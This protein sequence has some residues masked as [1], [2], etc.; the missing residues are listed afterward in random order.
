MIQSNDCDDPIAQCLNAMHK[1]P[2][3]K[4]PNCWV[5]LVHAS[6][7][8]AL[9]A[10]S[11]R[12]WPD[13]LIDFG[14][15]L[16][17]AWQISEGRVLYRDIASLF[18]PLSP[19]VNALWFTLFGVS[20][21]T[22]VICNLAI[23][24]AMVAGIHRFVRIATD[25][26][27]ATAASLTVL[28]LFGFCQ[29]LPIGNYNF[30][31]PYSHEAT[32]GIALTIAAL[33]ALQQGLIVRK[34]RFFALAGV[35][36]GLAMLTK[37]EIALAA[38][39]ATCV[40]MAGG[41]FIAPHDGRHRAWSLASFLAA[42]IVP[43]ALFFSYFTAF[44]SASEALRGIG[45]A[46]TSA[47]NASILTNNFYLRGMGLESPAANGV[48]MLLTF[49][50]VMLFLGAAVVVSRLKRGGRAARLALLA[51]A[52][53][54]VQSRTWPAALPALTLT[55]LV[56]ALID[57]WHLGDDRT[58][59]IRLWSL[60]IWAAFALVLLAKIGLNARIVHYGFYLALPATVTAVVLLSS[61]VPNVVA[62]IYG[63]RPGVRVRQMALWTLAAAIA[64]YIG[65][66]H[67][68]YRAKTL[69]I[70]AGTEVIYASARNDLWQGAAVRDA[71]LEL[72]RLAAP[73]ATV[74]VLPE[75]VMLNFLTRRPSPL[76]VVNLMPPEFVAFGEGEVLR[77][78]R[79]A[80]PDFVLLVHK[81]TSEYGYPLFGTD[82]RYGSD[83]LDWVRAHYRSQRVI[84]RRPMTAD[85]F[86]IEIL[87]RASPPALPRLD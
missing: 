18:G 42:A 30:V 2:I 34:R 81:N 54:C 28:L 11:W 65:L 16:Y 23:L 5:F 19:Y 35:C 44:M 58:K 49:A 70:G 86:G 73:G 21:L 12:K 59:A 79:Q 41:W 78:L 33:V 74:A 63:A 25:W 57:L 20:F 56:V 14:R 29:Y 72:N 38:G 7:F 15:E 55:V 13:P 17:V 3:T 76:R 31:T 1:L 64:P 37:P 87:S 48:R 82:A 53:V 43:A 36:V 6:V 32:H 83:V 60:T 62:S 85:G 67:G 84:G 26:V 50:A 45:G 9:A 80:P 27:T 39:A 47:T 24:A 68:W 52:I 51:A 8:A 40:A 4:S 10:W 66:S 46:W 22:I 75:G 77:S 61:I 71:Q 69:P